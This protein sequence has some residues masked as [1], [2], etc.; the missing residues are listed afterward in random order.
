MIRA[1]LVD[2]ITI[3][4]WNDDDKWNEDNARIE[5][6][7]NG[8]VDWKTRLIRDING[9]EVVSSGS[10]YILYDENLTHKDRLKI[11][12]VE[13]AIITVKPLKDFSRTAQE[14][15]LA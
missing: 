15:F 3:L 12:G 4:R 1:Y 7:I 9:E 13:Y 14:V 10:A 2:S 6:N 5:V 8:Y 11:D